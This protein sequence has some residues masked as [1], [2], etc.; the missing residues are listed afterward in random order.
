MAAN[1][2]KFGRLVSSSKK[3]AKHVTMTQELIAGRPNRAPTH[4]GAILREDVLP[5]LGIGVTEL[6]RNLRVTRQQVHR[7]LREE[8]GISSEMA[9]RLGKLCGNGPDLWDNMQKTYDRWSARRKL[10]QEIESIPTL[11]AVH[12]VQ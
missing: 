11:Q 3:Q 8:A 2:G 9:L 7:I 6:A 5:A 10:G 4:P 12:Q 1:T